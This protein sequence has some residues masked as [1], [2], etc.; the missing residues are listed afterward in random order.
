M[1]LV[2]EDPASKVADLK[3]KQQI[4]GHK[5]TQVQTLSQ[6]LQAQSNLYQQV[7]ELLNTSDKVRLS[8]KVDVTALDALP[9]AELE[10]VVADLEKDFYC[11]ICFKKS[12]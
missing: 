2:G 1:I 8:H 10:K 11:W 12:F 7:Y 4:L 9:L 6:Q 5:Q 3:A